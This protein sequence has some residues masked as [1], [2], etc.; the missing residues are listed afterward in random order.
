M[1]RA[2]F[3]DA[4]VQHIDPKRAHFHKRCTHLT[5]KVS[6]GGVTIH[7]QDG[8]TAEADVVLGADGIKSA[9]RRYVTDSVS[10]VIDPHVKFSNTICYRSL[11]PVSKAAKAGCK[12]DYSDRPIC[13]TGKNKHLI[14]FTVRGGTVVRDSCLLLSS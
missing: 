3:L 2:V 7:F 8:T 9:V 6:D 11:I 5:E 1:H 12:L 14:I 4:L 10:D 13:F